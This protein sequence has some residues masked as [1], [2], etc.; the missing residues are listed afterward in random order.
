MGKVVT[1]R[2][3]T[4]RQVQNL[5]GPAVMFAT[6]IG[7]GRAGARRNA[8]GQVD[9]YAGPEAEIEF[10]LRLV[11]R[12]RSGEYGLEREPRVTWKG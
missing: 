11:G 2:M 5:A 6:K 4:A 9:R 12:P 1:Q 3:A 7:A 8:D 10:V